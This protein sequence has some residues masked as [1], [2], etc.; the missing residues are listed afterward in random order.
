MT[1]LRTTTTTEFRKRVYFDG[2]PSHVFNDKCLTPLMKA[3]MYGRSEQVKLILEEKPLTVVERDGV[4][5][6]ALHYCAENDEDDADCAKLLLEADPSIVD[7]PDD[8]GH[9]ALHLAVIAGNLP[10]VRFLLVSGQADPNKRDAEG[11]STVHWATVCAD[12]DALEL[13][14]SHGGTTSSADVH[15]GYA[16]HYAAQMCGNGACRSGD[17]RNTGVRVL[18]LLLSFGADVHVA[19]KHG[20]QPILWA[21]SAGS[22]DAIITLVN[23][24]ANVESHDK[25]GLTALHCA[26]SRGHVECV[27][28][29]L[30]LC[31]CEV[32]A[33]DSNSCSALFYAVTLGHA[34]A[35]EMLL[36]HGANPDRQDGKGRTPA[37]CG[38]FKGQLETVR[39]LAEHGANLWLRNSKGGYPLHDA[40][41]SGRKELVLWLISMRPESVDYYDDDGKRPLHIAALNNNL[42]MSKIILDNGASINPVMKI[43]GERMT[44]LDVALRKNN[45]HLAKFLNLFGGKPASKLNKTLSKQQS[46]VR[47]K[48]KRIESRRNSY[49]SDSISRKYRNG[50]GRK[51]QL[52]SRKAESPK[53]N[54]TSKGRVVQVHIRANVL[55]KTVG[56]S[57]DDRKSCGG[58]GGTLPKAHRKKATGVANEP[59]ECFSENDMCY[60]GDGDNDFDYDNYDDDDHYDDDDEDDEDDDEDDVADDGDDDCAD[61]G[62]GGV[63]EQT[64]GSAAAAAADHCGSSRRLHRNRRRGNRIATRGGSGGGRR[65]RDKVTSKA[66]TAADDQQELR[67]DGIAGKATSVEVGG[68]GS[69]KP[70]GANSAPGEL[71]RDGVKPK[72]TTE[73]VD[74]N[75]D[76]IRL[77]DGQAPVKAKIEGNIDH[78][79]VSVTGPEETSHDNHDKRE[80]GPTAAFVIEQEFGDLTVDGSSVTKSGAPTLTAKKGGEATVTEKGNVAERSTSR[81]GG[82]TPMKGQPDSGRAIVEVLDRVDT[83]QLSATVDGDGDVG[84][85][86]VV[87]SRNFVGEPTAFSV[88]PD[89]G[90]EDDRPCECPDCCKRKP[91]RSTSKKIKSRIPRLNNYCSLAPTSDLNTMSVT[92]AVQLS[93]R[94]YNL[95][96]LIFY[97]LSELKRLQIRAGKSDERVLV[98]RLVEEYGSTGL[99]TGLKR[100]DGPF[101]FKRFEKYLYDQLLVLQKQSLAN[102][103]TAVPRV[104]SIDEVEKLAGALR[105][106]DAGKT[107]LENP[108][109][110]LSCVR[111]TNRCFHATHAYTG[112]P[113]AAYIPKFRLDHHQMP[114]PPA[115]DGRRHRFLPDIRTGQDISGGT[116]TRCLRNVDP[117]RPITLQ[118][119]NGPCAQAIDLPTD[120]LDKNRR[121]FVTFTIKGAGDGSRN[122]H[123][124]PA[125]PAFRSDGRRGHAVDCNPPL[126]HTHAKSF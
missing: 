14:L 124:P 42:E 104:Q 49:S 40:M 3:C 28:G 77:T 13:V 33:V 84:V 61:G 63:E 102:D 1:T 88:L 16:V 54:K 55:T 31:G 23:G 57:R 91:S 5:K 10:L 114:K 44:P 119:G 82:K 45:R 71:D 32:D 73:N 92:K 115:D 43:K 112:V 103:K 117:S 126:A 79:L 89:A 100:Y 118:L 6:T 67:T 81:E 105:R 74:A 7:I 19:D 20:R 76:G 106:I 83:P 80:G 97:Q 65:R 53:P 29:L 98:K 36:E 17:A 108:N 64:N 25:D 95:E 99:F 51:K 110:C 50:G 46:T 66:N 93:S 116:T 21:A 78:P 87:G 34:D 47:V 2:S 52:N 120:K 12:V 15:G 27:D 59:K 8:D 69:D 86:V 48:T 24:G 123:R 72:T 39:L 41:R 11:H 107:V 113:C 58:G 38:A 111:T 70:I 56:K 90:R 94:K 35:T 125:P 60:G 26:A 109:D 68:G 62:G 85:G 4:F 9:T 22:A 37:H 30:T 101:S 122:R 121:Y 96:R 18:Q 75:H